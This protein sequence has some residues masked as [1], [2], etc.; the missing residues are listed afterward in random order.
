MIGIS[1]ETQTFLTF[2]LEEYRMTL[3][4]SKALPFLED[5]EDEDLFI[6]NLQRRLDTANGDPVFTETDIQFLQHICDTHK[7]NIEEGS[8][9]LWNKTPKEDISQ[10]ESAMDEVRAAYEST[11]AEWMT[12]EGYSGTYQV[13][14]KLNLYRENSNLYVGLD[15]FD[16]D[17]GG[18][19][20]FT[21]LTVNV[22]ALPYLHSAIDTNNNGQQAV[23]F[24]EAH[25]FGK[26]TDFSIPSGFCLFP[27]FKF[28]E[29]KLREIDPQVFAEYAK[30]HNVELRPLKDQLSAAEKRVSKKHKREEEDRSMPNPER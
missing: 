1:Q 10:A 15:F 27:V 9:G 23:D 11:K 14:P 22:G 12:Y 13:L 18:F 29:D 3:E 25:G 8:A 7:R 2:M 16:L 24:L 5:R 20:P 6:D 17:F 28:N 19:E 4:H 21:D 26:K 30:A